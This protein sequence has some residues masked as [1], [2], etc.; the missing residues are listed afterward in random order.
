[1]CWEGKPKNRKVAKRNIPVKKL[2][3]K[4]HTSPYQGFKYVSGK[5]YKE[6]LHPHPLWD[7]NTRIVL[8]HGLHCYSDKCII[9]ELYENGEKHICVY[10]PLFSS[11]GNFFKNIFFGKSRGFCLCPY[12]KRRH[13]LVSG[14][15]PVGS[16]YYENTDGEIVSEGLVLN[17]PKKEK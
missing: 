12:S 7:D 15:I 8:N 13:I 11:V 2:L 1:M 9:K 5:Q 4:D 10:P 14:F 17:I 3:Y 16:V 6:E